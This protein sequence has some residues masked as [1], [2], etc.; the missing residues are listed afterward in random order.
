MIFRVPGP[1]GITWGGNSIGVTK[2]GV[3][4][5]STPNWVP[6]IDDAHGAEPADYLWAGKIITVECIGL[7]EDLITIADP[8]VN[9]LGTGKVVGEH[10]GQDT[11]HYALAITE[12]DGVSIWAAAHVEPVPV[13][14]LLTATQE[15]QVPLTFMILLDSSGYLFNTIPSYLPGV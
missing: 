6:I 8:F 4:I 15:L 12:R 13:E 3:I 11:T 2:A 14:M 5:R 7:H 9:S 10:I 1:C